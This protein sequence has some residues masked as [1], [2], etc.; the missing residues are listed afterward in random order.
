MVFHA[1][2]RKYNIFMYNFLH[3]SYSKSATLHKESANFNLIHLQATMRVCHGHNFRIGFDK[4][5]RK[6][7]ENLTRN[8][9]ATVA[10][11]ISIVAVPKS[12]CRSS[13]ELLSQLH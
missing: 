8:S 10:L 11:W 3:G 5:I 4:L 9:N 7:F 6:T 12:Y 2:V 13:K 1:I